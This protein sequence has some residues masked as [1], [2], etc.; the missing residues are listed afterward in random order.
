MRVRT[1]AR[2]PS[3]AEPGVGPCIKTIY[4][5]FECC[6]LPFACYLCAARLQQS[7]T[8]LPFTAQAHAGR[9]RSAGRA[10]SHGIQ[11][12]SPAS[13]C[14]RKRAAAAHSRKPAQR[15]KTQGPPVQ[16]GPLQDHLFFPVPGSCSDC[17]S[18]SCDVMR[19]LCVLFPNGA[20]AR[21]ALAGTGCDIRLFE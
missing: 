21:Q 1:L 15:R 6:V 8:C 9:A 13:H 7:L 20:A 3:A 2:S 19:P 5:R 10:A 12:I 11:A 17:I 4:I 14:S 16:P 18:M